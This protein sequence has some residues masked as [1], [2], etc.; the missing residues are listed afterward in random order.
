MVC[1]ERRI[2]MSRGGW[3]GYGGRQPDPAADPF[4][5]FDDALDWIGC[6]SQCVPAAERDSILSRLT[7]TDD[8][9]TKE[10]VDA[11]TKNRIIAFNAEGLFANGLLFL[12]P[13]CCLTSAYFR[14]CEPVRLCIRS[15][16]FWRSILSLRPD[17]LRPVDGP[18]LH[19]T[20]ADVIAARLDMEQDVLSEADRKEIASNLARIGGRLDYLVP[21]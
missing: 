6:P 17:R 18:A 15:G 7:R 20:M 1:G 11:L 4:S 19:T 10:I 8:A 14:S 13:R 21:Y 5:S 3:Y 12:S 16:I 2:S 9:S